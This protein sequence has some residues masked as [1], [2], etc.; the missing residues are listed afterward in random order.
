M[1]TRPIPPIPF[2]GEWFAALPV[3]WDFE[4]LRGAADC[5][6]KRLIL[7]HLRPS[8]GT[9]ACVPGGGSTSTASQQGP[10]TATWFSTPS[11]RFSFLRTLLRVRLAASLL[12]S[13]EGAHWPPPHFR[14]LY[15]ASAEELV[16]QPS[17][18]SPGPGWRA[19]PCW[20]SSEA[21]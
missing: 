12:V 17:S 21:V 4:A 19:V 18:G 15:R 9:H 16:S 6:E 7:V 1:T 13:P 2:R 8:A 5:V 3:L 14:L 20:V 10:L 11:M